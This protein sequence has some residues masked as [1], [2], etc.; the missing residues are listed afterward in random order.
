MHL[1]LL[2]LFLRH[3]N[4]SQVLFLSKAIN[5]LPSQNN[6]SSFLVM[7]CLAVII[8]YVHCATMP[9]DPIV[10]PFILAPRLFLQLV[11]S[12]GVTPSETSFSQDV[13]PSG[14]NRSTYFKAY[15]YHIFKEILYF[16]LT[17]NQTFSTLGLPHTFL[18]YP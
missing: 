16:H 5:P 12:Q 10:S 11:L 15:S 3:I 17:L 2:V 1:P 13:I 18:P 9:Q 7:C 14:T 6:T 4:K 8:C